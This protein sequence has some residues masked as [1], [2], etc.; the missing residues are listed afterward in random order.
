VGFKPFKYWK[1]QSVIKEKVDSMD[2]LYIVREGE[3]EIRKFIHSIEEEG[4]KWVQP[5]S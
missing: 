4:Y 5:D 3:F 1:W 2:M